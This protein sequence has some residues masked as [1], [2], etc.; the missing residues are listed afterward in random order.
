[1]REYL[2]QIVEIIAKLSE[3]A[4]FENKN[5]S[6]QHMVSDLN[7]GSFTNNSSTGRINK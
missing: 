4:M 1:M 6:E 3:N 7:S 5:L 2:R